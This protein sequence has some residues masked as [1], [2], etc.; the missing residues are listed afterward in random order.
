MADLND[1]RTRITTLDNNLLKLLSERRELAIEVAKSKQSTSKPVRDQDR[2][3]QLLVRLINQG[4]ELGLD[5]NYI[6]NIYHTVLEDSVLLQQAFLQEI[7][8]PNA[9]V[10][11]A[12]VAFLGDKGSY[13]NLACKKYFARQDDRLV[14]LGF[15]TFQKIITAVEKGQ[16][17]Y[18]ML[19][20]ENTSSGSIND[21]YDLLQH[22]TLSIVGELTQPIEHSLITTCDTDLS[23]I[24][25]IYAHPQ[26][27]AQ[28]SLFLSAHPHIKIEFVDS[29]SAAMAK[30]KE[31]NSEN[32][33]AIG[34]ITGGELYGLQ[35]IRTGLA[36]QTENYSRFIVVARK[37]VDVAVQIPAKTTFTM[38]TGQQ[39]GCLVEAL[40]V[41]REQGINMT[42]LESRPIQGNPWEE[43]FYID[44]A[45]N[46]QSEKM[47]NVIKQL[48]RITNQLKVLG[49]YPS[50]DVA[51]TDVPAE[52]L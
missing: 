39:A 51:A 28:C 13:S 40:L 3:Q 25:T 9:A 47:Q 8:N 14:E 24:K 38:S 27:F 19:P 44:V 33:A 7:K 50:E 49:C 2:E 34:S 21:V 41:L 32:A 45:A 29:S 17:D 11:V 35:P 15:P 4:R 1:I 37:P 12:R 23:K 46:L 42:K 26:P 43:M 31:L 18:G 16:A 30:V 20:I 52:L 6:M 22:T 10:S 5:S 36:N 48:T